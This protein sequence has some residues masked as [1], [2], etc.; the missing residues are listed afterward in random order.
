MI[1]NKAVFITITLGDI[2]FYHKDYELVKVFVEYN[3]IIQ[4]QSATILGSQAYLPV[5]VIY[6]T[7]RALMKLRRTQEILYGDTK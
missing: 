1:E 4:Q 3:S 7:P 5:S 2:N 6:S